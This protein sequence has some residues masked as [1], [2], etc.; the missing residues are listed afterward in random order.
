MYRKQIYK[1]TEYLLHGTSDSVDH[2]YETKHAASK[3][4]VGFWAK[5]NCTTYNGKV[6]RVDLEDKDVP[7]EEGII[8]RAFCERI[9]GSDKLRYKG[10]YTIQEDLDALAKRLL[11]LCNGR[12]KVNREGGDIVDISKHLVKGCEEEYQT[13]NSVLSTTMP[14][15]IDGG[16]D[17]QVDPSFLCF[18]SVDMV[19]LESDIDSANSIQYRVDRLLKGTWDSINGHHFVPIREVST[20]SSKPAEAPLVIE[21]VFTDDNPS[22]ETQKGVE[23][24]AVVY[25]KRKPVEEQKGTGIVHVGVGP[26]DY[27]VDLPKVKD[28]CFPFHFN[29]LGKVYF[30]F[31]A[32][33][34]WGSFDPSVRK[35]VAIQEYL[36]YKEKGEEKA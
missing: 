27:V 33:D 28:G 12:F 4:L 18:F 9:D 17:D 14:I 34:A 16:I 3:A 20:C 26:V 7:P 10:Y 31:K 21:A 6:I 19:N 32:S 23:S 2:Y 30:Y 36:S 29:A 11:K 25:D 5:G 15:F 24:A 22:V 8:V 13:Y 35:H 1:V